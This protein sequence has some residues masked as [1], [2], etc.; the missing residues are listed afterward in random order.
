MISCIPGGWRKVR[1]KG[2]WKIVFYLWHNPPTPIACSLQFC[3]AHLQVIIGHFIEL[4]ALFSHLRLKFPAHF[5]SLWRTAKRLWRTFLFGLYISFTPPNDL[6]PY[7]TGCHVTKLLLS[8]AF[9][10]YI[11]IS[12]WKAA[13]EKMV[14]SE[15]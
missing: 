7:L 3:T 8:G 15:K 11:Y 1:G 5:T 12:H 2:R 6:L 10:N 4:F 14:T 9:V 13:R